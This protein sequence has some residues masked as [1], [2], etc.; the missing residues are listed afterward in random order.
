MTSDEL[1]WYCTTPGVYPTRCVDVGQI[2]CTS[3]IS[4][5]WVISKGKIIMMITLVITIIIV[6]DDKVTFIASKS[7]EANLSNASKHAGWSMS[8]QVKVFKL[9]RCG[10]LDHGATVKTTFMFLF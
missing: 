10:W 3:S 1:L 7:L 2:S 9:S 5:G 4:S 6:N 8:Q